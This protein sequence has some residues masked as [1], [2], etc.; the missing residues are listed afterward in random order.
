MKKILLSSVLCASIAFGAD[1]LPVEKR[2]FT[3]S[4]FIPDISLIMDMSYVNRSIDDH[5]AG[6]LDVPGVV[7]GLLGSHSHGSDNHATYNVKNGFNLNYAELLLSSSVDPFFTMDGVF[8]FSENGVEIEELYFTT[9]ALGYGA[10]VK[11]GKFSSN[12]G[13]LNEQHHHSWDFADMPLVYESFLGMHG[14]NEVGV[15]LQWIAPTD[16]YMM[17]GA[18]VLQGTNEQMFGNEEVDLTKINITANPDEAKAADAPSLFIVYAKTSFDIQDTTILAGLS[19]A[20]GKSRINHSEHEGPSVF[21]GDSTLYG[22]DLVIKH[23]FDSY[24]S[25]KWQSEWMLRDM[26]GVQYANNTIGAFIS[27]SLTKNQAGLYSQL[28]YAHD[29]NWK[30]GVRYDTI[31]HNDVEVNG[32]NKNLSTDIDKYSA[33]LEYSTSEFARFRLQY[34]RNNALY[35]EDG[36]QQKIDTIMFQVN[37]SIGAHAAHSF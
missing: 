33:M 31:Y 21:S 8:H 14:I 1:M 11:G 19:Y 9:T 18:E 20:Q 35:N 4:K 17:L 10:R 5:E 16:T 28:I 22:A 6:L 32:V 24:S 34:D 27:P 25:L 37:I 12:F 13:Y 7:H 36:V 29:R 30:M 3:Q 2:T 26:D 23:Y 15:Q